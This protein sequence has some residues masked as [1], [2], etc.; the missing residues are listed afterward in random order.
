M[1]E[2]RPV[3][4]CLVAYPGVDGIVPTQVQIVDLAEAEDA[5]RNGWWV[6]G[7]DPEDEDNLYNW[8]RAYGLVDNNNE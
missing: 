4:K 8:L 1:G 5:F 7:P 3:V 2:A 6:I